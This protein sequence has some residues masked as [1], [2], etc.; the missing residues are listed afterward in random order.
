MSGAED[1]KSNCIT[2]HMPKIG[3][4][5][6]TIRK[7]DTHSFH[8]F[9]GARNAPEMLSKY[10]E[11]NYKRLDKGFE[12]TV[13]NNTPHPLMTHPLR[14][15]E[16]HTTITRDGKEQKLKKHTFI[17]VIGREGKPSMPWLA[18]QIVKDT[19]LKANEKRV[20][21]FETKLQDGDEIEVILGYRVVNEKAS[22]KL[23]IDKKH[24]KF[25]PLKSA[26]FR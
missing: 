2:C 22:Q 5:A 19:M 13:H 25:I 3:G 16:L 21:S 26:Y 12:I 20:I 24:S 17:K 10:V 23:G 6:T 15:V 8:G 11:L 9:A 4:T 14:V 18:T 1:K 7:T